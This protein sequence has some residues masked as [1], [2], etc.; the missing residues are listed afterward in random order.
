GGSPDLVDH[1]HG[2]RVVLNGATAD[3]TR[4]TRV[5]RVWSVAHLAGGR[6][7]RV[8]H[9]RGAARHHQRRRHH[10]GG[11]HPIPTGMSR[12]TNRSSATSTGFNGS[13]NPS[14]TSSAS[15][16]SSRSTR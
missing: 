10:V 7:L 15:T 1:R 2:V 8:L 6:V 5:L 11:H 3:R 12:P 16:C 14:V 13:T 9:M 4:V